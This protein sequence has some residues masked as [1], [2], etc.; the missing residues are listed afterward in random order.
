MIDANRAADFFANPN[1]PDQKPLTDWIVG[2][3]GRLVFGG[4]NAIELERVAIAKAVLV[5]WLR[6]G[7]A[8]RVRDSDVDQ[9]QTAVERLPLRSD[10]PHVLALSRLS[11][12]RV[13]YTEDR[14]LM[15]D[16][17]DRNLVPTPK[18]KVYRNATHARILGWACSCPAAPRRRRR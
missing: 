18:G 2:R 16:F 7:L 17:T 8:V 9:E 13:L 11:G 10:D 5:E 6:S 14:A 4:T 15:D 3:R 12:A 1:A